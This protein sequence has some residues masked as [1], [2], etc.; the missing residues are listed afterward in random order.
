MVEESTVPVI[1]TGV[2][3]CH[4]YIDA[5]ADIDKAVRL[6]VN[7]KTQRTERVQRRRDVPGARRYR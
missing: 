4:V 6:L 2:G 7:S 1:E 5:D 3:N